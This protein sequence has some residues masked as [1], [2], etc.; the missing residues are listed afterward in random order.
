[1]AVDLATH[2]FPAGC[3]GAVLAC[4]LCLPA[5]VHSEELPDPTRPPVSVS[6]AA[7]QDEPAKPTGLQSVLISKNRKAAI[8]DGE[9]V[10]LGGK[11]GDYKLTEVSNAGVVLRGAQGKRVLTLFPGVSIKKRQ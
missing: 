4:A 5:A 1:M 2:R 8:I 6:A 3:C 11:Y 9:T 10:E 7:I